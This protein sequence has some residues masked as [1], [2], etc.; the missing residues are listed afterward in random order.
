MRPARG[1][2][3]SPGGGKSGP[4]TFVSLVSKE[5]KEQQVRV[6]CCCCFCSCCFVVAV[7]TLR[8]IERGGLWMEDLVLLWLCLLTLLAF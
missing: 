3:C 2:F 5:E 7:V 1:E 6:C 4:L 8:H